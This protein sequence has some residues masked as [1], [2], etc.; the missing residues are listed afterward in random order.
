MFILLLFKLKLVLVGLIN[1]KVDPLILSVLDHVVIDAWFLIFF[2]LGIGSVGLKLDITVLELS[3]R[4]E[5][6][7]YEQLWFIKSILP[8]NFLK[9]V[10]QLYALIFFIVYLHIFLVLFVIDS[11]YALHLCVANQLKLV[12]RLLSFLQLNSLLLVRCWICPSL[13]TWCSLL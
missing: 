10:I 8:F 2:L 3:D 1:V 5:D 12:E 9:L 6:A 4:F 7:S 13:L 11:I